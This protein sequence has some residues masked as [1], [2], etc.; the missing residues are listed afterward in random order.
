MPGQTVCQGHPGFTNPDVS[1]SAGWTIGTADVYWDERQYRGSRQ[2]RELIGDD[3]RI[4]PDSSVLAASVTRLAE[5]NVWESS[6]ARQGL[7][8]Q[9]RWVSGYRGGEKARPS[10]NSR[11]VAGVQKGS[12]RW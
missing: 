11:N 2:G 12:Y 4:A 9:W 10:W 6:R 8:F 5:R 3:N 1:R 7:G